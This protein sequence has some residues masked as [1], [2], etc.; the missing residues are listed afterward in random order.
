MQTGT[1]WQWKMEMQWEYH[2]NKSRL[3]LQVPSST[4]HL[5]SK[6]SPPKQFI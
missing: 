3:V 4:I 5:L 2:T 6:E 1:G